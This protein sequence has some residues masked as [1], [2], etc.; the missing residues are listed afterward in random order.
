MAAAAAVVH[1]PSRGR[2]LTVTTAAGASGLALGAG[3][4]KLAQLISKLR[5]KKKKPKGRRSGPGQ[6]QQ[7][8]GPAAAGQ[9]RRPEQGSGSGR[10]G[11]TRGRRTNRR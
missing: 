8:Q 7:Q 3:C 2:R 4:I 5:G 10:T 1:L 9:R 6:Q 11:S